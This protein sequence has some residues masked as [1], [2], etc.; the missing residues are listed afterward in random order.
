MLQQGLSCRAGAGAEL[1]GTVLGAPVPPPALLAALLARLLLLLRIAAAR[2]LGAFSASPRSDPARP[3]FRGTQGRP[4][5]PSFPP[6]PAARSRVRVS[7][8]IWWQL[9]ASITH[10]DAICGEGTEPAPAAQDRG[11]TGRGLGGVHGAGSHLWGAGCTRRGVTSPKSGSGQAVCGSRRCPEAGGSGPKAGCLWGGSGGGRAGW[12]APEP[13]SICSFHLSRCA[14]QSRSP[15]Q[16]TFGFGGRKRWRKHSDGERAARKVPRLASRCLPF[17]AV[18]PKR[19]KAAAFSAAAA[20]RC[21]PGKKPPG[22]FLPGKRRN[23]GVCAQTSARIP[24]AGIPSRARRARAA[25]EAMRG[26]RRGAPRERGRATG[27]P[28]RRQIVSSF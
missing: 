24:A 27:R 26:R 8:G 22:R 23:L 18:P 11:G 4:P 16:K 10:G 15:C 19:G 17:P 9:A 25:W 7:W 2:S 14:P 28:D 21:W 20:A 13:F 12:R 5:V 1:P 3:V 6:Q